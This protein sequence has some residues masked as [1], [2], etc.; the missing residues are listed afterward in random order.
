MQIK[1]ADSPQVVA[2]DFTQWLIHLLKEKDRF[3]IALSGGSTPAVLFKLWADNYSDT[4]D[5]SKIHFFWGDERCVPP[6]DEESNFKMTN[7]LLFT[8]VG[9]PASNIH[10]VHGEVTPT[11]EAKHYAKVIEDNV[12]I[13]DGLPRF[14]LVMLGMG[15]DGHTASIFPHQMELLTEK[16]WCAVATHPESGQKRVSLTGPV[17][18]N[19]ANVA[20]LV[21]GT[22]KT[23]KVQSILQGEDTS[24]NYPAA[25]IKP[26]KGTL[27][28][29][30]DKAA[31]GILS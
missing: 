30:L 11:E 17:I 29:F 2:A 28:W 24:E 13:I 4:I 20:F 22:S 3:T 18:N 12:E 26:P 23:E 8:K 16:A 25:H 27:Y 9:V 15:G 6:S 14:D 21:T 19:A 1:I 5:W 31:A 10:R 7:D